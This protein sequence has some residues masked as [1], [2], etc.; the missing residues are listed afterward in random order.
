[1]KRTVTI[2]ILLCTLLLQGSSFWD[3]T[4]LKKHVKI[5]SECKTPVRIC[6][7]STSPLSFRNEEKRV[8]HEGDVYEWD[9]RTPAFWLFDLTIYLCHVDFFELPKGHVSGYFSPYTRLKCN[10]NTCT[11][12]LTNHSTMELY[13][14]RER[15]WETHWPLET[16]HAAST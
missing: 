14:E 13:K 8:M 10:T 5:I 7:W 1:M 2:L 15:Y 11:W 4:F 6:C 16:E 12:R 3:S 9:F